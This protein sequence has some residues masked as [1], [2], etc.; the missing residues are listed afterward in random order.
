MV[1]ETG[2][3]SQ[4]LHRSKQDLTVTDHGPRSRVLTGQASSRRMGQTLSF[5]CK[6]CRLTHDEDRDMCTMVPRT[7]GGVECRLTHDEDRDRS[8]MVHNNTQEDAGSE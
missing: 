6:E 2:R 1:S 7:V 4:I 8:A 3:L 5:G